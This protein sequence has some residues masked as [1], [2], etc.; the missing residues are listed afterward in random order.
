MARQRLFECSEL[1]GAA[2]VDF[3]CGDPAA[4]LTDEFSISDQAVIPLWVA[5]GQALTDE[6]AKVIF[7]ADTRFLLVTHNLFPQEDIPTHTTLYTI[8]VY[9]NAE[10]TN[11]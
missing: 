2:E 3:L 9:Y 11:V 7:M 6:F 5:V 10:P 1:D 8:I 4:A